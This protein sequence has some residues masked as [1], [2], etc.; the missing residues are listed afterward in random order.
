[1]MFVYYYEIL[2][3]MMSSYF[4]IWNYTVGRIRD[5]VVQI[6]MVVLVV[7]VRLQCRRVERHL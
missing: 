1:M 6:I 2:P 3:G 4:L 5:V 7:V